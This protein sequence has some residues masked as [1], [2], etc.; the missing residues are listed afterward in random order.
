MR[1]QLDQE[2]L[3]EAIQAFITS[4]GID[5]TNIIVDIDLTAGRGPNGFT[6]IVALSKKETETESV[7]SVVPKESL[8]TEAIVDE[9]TEIDFDD[10]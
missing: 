7:T 2:E 3:E 4:Q 9:D 8:T 1:I 6:A 5:L 10:T